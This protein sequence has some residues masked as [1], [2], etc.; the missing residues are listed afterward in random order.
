MIYDTCGINWRFTIDIEYLI[1]LRGPSCPSW[2]IPYL[3]KQSQFAGGQIDIKSFL[4]G[5]YGNMTA[6]R[7]R[8]NKANS[9]PIADIRPEIY[10][11]G[12]RNSKHE[13]RK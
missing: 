10:A 13:I 4:K 2:F 7:P 11:L 8:K 3:K 12:I 1:F 5:I 9:K 6:F